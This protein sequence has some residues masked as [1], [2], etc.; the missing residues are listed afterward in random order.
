MAAAPASAAI[1]IRWGAAR[2][3]EP[4]RNGGFG[5][6]ACPTAGMCVA[7]DQ[8]GYIVTSTNPAGGAW[9]ATIPVDKGNPLTGISC[10]TVK[11]C[12]AVDGAGNV[13][14]STDPTG[15]AKAWSRPIRIDS[16]VAPGGGYAGLADVSCPTVSLCVAVDSGLPGNIVA[17]TRPTGG[18]SAWKL[19][20][21]SGSV[22]ASVSCQS[23]TLCVAGGSQHFYST[24]PAGG[25]STWHG[26][27][28][29]AADDLYGDIACPSL[30]TC[31]GV[32]YGDA[33][34]GFTTG[35]SKPTGTAS[36]WVTVGLE[37]QP[38]AQG[39]GLLDA[40]GCMSGV[41][42]VAVDSAD[43]AFTTN[44]PVR[45]VWNGPTVVAPASSPTSTSSAI[46]CALRLCVIVDSNG[47]AVA[48]VRH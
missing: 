25:A 8:S 5:D 27:G 30:T 39:T 42:C 33:S 44:A 16:T 36:D 6:V 37:P 24:T 45:G 17:T 47:Y 10:P 9:S 23:A 35:S 21:I 13:I 14:T 19:A 7:V 32:G 26:T 46:G 29:P 18:A 12:V 3:I 48:G 41:F 1:S 11:L 34:T 31:L 4:A 43:L 38:P 22:L 20:G 40:V 28:S 15:G 2:R